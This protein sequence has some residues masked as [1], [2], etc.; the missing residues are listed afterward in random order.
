MPEAPEAKYLE[1]MLRKAVL[2]KKILKITSNTKTTKNLPKPSKVVDS[3]SRGKIFWLKTEDY[4]V[5][6]HM[7]LTGWLTFWEPKIYKYVLHF[8]GIDVWLKD[9]RRFSR[10]DIFKTDTDHKKALGKIGTCIFCPDFT[11]EKFKELLGNGKRNISAFLLD[12]K[13]LA[14]VGNYIRNDA[15]YIA[16][17]S[18]KRKINDLTDTEKKK[19]Y[20]AIMFVI[21]SSLKTWLED[22]NIPIPSR[23]SKLAPKRLSVP[24]RM[25]VYDREVDQAGRKIKKEMFAGRKTFWVPEKQM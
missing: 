4:W 1:L 24:Y 11:L 17:I 19:L 7:G 8:D 23:L 15:L 12:Q 16:G 21:Y 14:G 13:K 5:H 20:E 2:G 6:L 22:E 3:G 18:P 25:R 9:Q 10:I